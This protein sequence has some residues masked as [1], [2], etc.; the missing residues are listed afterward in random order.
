MTDGAVVEYNVAS[1]THMR[2]SDPYVA[3]WNYESDGTV[4]QFNEAYNTQTQTD[5]QGFDIDDY[6]ERTVVQ[7]N[8]SHD[9]VGGF[10][11]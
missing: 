9:N 8:Y 11:L 5:G 1:W 4:M 3:I 10:M 7:Y 6:T 2:P